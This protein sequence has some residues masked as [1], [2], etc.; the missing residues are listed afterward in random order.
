MKKQFKDNRGA[1]SVLNWG[2]NVGEPSDHLFHAFS[3]A[4]AEPKTDIFEELLA[5]PF[6]PGSSTVRN[7]TT[8]TNLA[9]EVDVA[10]PG[11]PRSLFSTVTIKADAQM[12]VDI[13]ET[14]SKNFEQFF[15]GGK[16]VS[17]TASIQSF[18]RAITTKV[19][20]GSNPQ[21]I[22]D[23]DDLLGMYPPF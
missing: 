22:T 18:G 5:I 6:I 17:W 3:Y 19:V 7:N 15:T 2:R 10:F 20:K 11:G 12:A 9:E 21:G 4:D 8:V 1:G 16:N 14:A 13:Y 23:K